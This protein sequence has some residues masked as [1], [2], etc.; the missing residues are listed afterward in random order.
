MN[1]PLNL[2]VSSRRPSFPRPF[3]A[4]A[5]F[6]FQI[7]VGAKAIAPLCSGARTCEPLVQWHRR[8]ERTVRRRRR[9]R[10][11]L[12]LNSP[13][14]AGGC[15][16]FEWYRSLRFA[17]E[18]ES[19]LTRVLGAGIQVFYCMFTFTKQVECD[20]IKAPDSDVRQGTLHFKLSSLTL[21]GCRGFGQGICGCF[22]GRG[23]D[24]ATRMCIHTSFGCR[25]SSAL[26][27]WK[28]DSISLAG[29]LP[30][31]LRSSWSTSTCRL[32]ET[33]WE[34]EP[35]LCLLSIDS[36]LLMPLP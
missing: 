19:V 5:D 29:G 6:H 10:G 1:F 11:N 33:L 2:E 25:C 36:T 4:I 18:N 34:L 9:R 14:L 31:L 23:W 12:H 15:G 8:K 28:F 16:C 7:A 35:Y 13:S 17:N 22:G 3:A 27:I 20:P 32:R 24:F 21:A 30:S 26:S